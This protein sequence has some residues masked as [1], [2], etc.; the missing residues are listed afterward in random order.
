[1]QLQELRSLF[2]VAL[3]FGHFM[4]AVPT[5][6][7]LGGSLGLGDDESGG[8]AEIYRLPYVKCIRENSVL[9]RSCN[10]FVGLLMVHIFLLNG[11]KFVAT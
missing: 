10:I 5:P 3:E 9:V 2:D 11:L 1:L 7:Q 4:P 8:F 6:F